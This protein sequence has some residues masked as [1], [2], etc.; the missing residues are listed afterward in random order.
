MNDKIKEILKEIELYLLVLAYA[1]IGFFIVMTG[2]SILPKIVEASR[3]GSYAPLVY[4]ISIA[5]GFVY[6]AYYKI[7]K[8][9]IKN[10]TKETKR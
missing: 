10:W 8:L 9:L 1:F 2:V 7:L 3:E 5:I 4:S 6:F